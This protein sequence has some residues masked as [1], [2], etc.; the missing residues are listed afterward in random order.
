MQSSQGFGGS[1]GH[2][3][4]HQYR[5]PHLGQDKIGFVFGNIAARTLFEVQPKALHYLFQ[6]IQVIKIDYH[7]YLN[8]VVW[9][10]SK[11][12]WN[13]QLV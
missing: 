2:C 11:I 1:P 7:S 8:M 4:P 6:R 13:I 12:M 9:E 5:Q 3:N 10:G